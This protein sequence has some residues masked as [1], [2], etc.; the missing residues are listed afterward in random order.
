[1]ML[2]EGMWGKTAKLSRN[3]L[4]Y[5]KVS[6]MKS[7]NNEG[8]RVPAGHIL[9]P[10]ESSRTGTGLHSTELLNKGIPW[11]SPSNQSCCQGNRL[12]SPNCQQG[13]RLKTT[14]V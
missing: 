7:P 10:N 5:M 3:F 1:M 2:R 9:S 11:K 8:D 13:P 4:K 12:L 6:Q 14:P